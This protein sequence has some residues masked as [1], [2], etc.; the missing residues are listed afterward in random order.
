MI[1]NLFDGPDNTTKVGGGWS[2][3]RNLKKGLIAKGHQISNRGYDVSM[4]CAPTMVSRDSWVL[5]AGKPRVLRT[6]GVPEDFRN[7][8]TGWSRMKQFAHQADL[9]IYQSKFVKNTIGRLLKE[10]GKII[11]NGVDTSIFRKDGDKMPRFGQPSI[12]FVHF[13]HDPN[14]RFQEV[15][16]RFRYYKIDNPNATMS[17]IGDYP[18]NQVF[19]NKKKRDFGM[20]D[21]KEGK[22]WR[23]MGI[24]RDRTQL[25]KALRS[26]D[27]VAYPSFDG[28]SE[29]II[30]LFSKKHNFSLKSMAERYVGCFNELIKRS[31]K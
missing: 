11:C 22:D 30:K 2:F 20:L 31:N 26:F 10:D 17:F 16:E 18:K 25:A 9:V 23:Y 19:W 29:E 12:V 28:S 21:L 14:K 13:R 27:Y 7:R 5:A 24:I 15:I 1:I 3:L 8:G 6:D 4:A